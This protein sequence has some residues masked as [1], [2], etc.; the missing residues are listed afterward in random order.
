MSTHPGQTMTIYDIPVCLTAVWHRALAPSNCANGLKAAGI[1][2]MNQSMPLLTRLVSYPRMMNTCR[3]NYNIRMSFRGVC[4]ASASSSASC[5]YG[6]LCYP[7]IRLLAYRPTIKPRT[8][9]I[10][11]T[12]YESFFLGNQPTGDIVHIHM[13]LLAR[14]LPEY[15]ALST[16]VMGLRHCGSVPNIS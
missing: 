11:I 9:A 14:Y 10:L 5:V 16:C 15:H 8:C 13:G 3:Y 4:T 2:P 7:S 1:W 12:C 6:V